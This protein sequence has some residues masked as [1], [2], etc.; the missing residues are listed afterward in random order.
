MGDLEFLFLLL[1]AAAALVR[2]ADVVRVPYPIVL[3]L[4]GLAAGYAPGSPELELEPEVVFL[5]FLPPL[6]YAAAW[7]ANPRELRAE[8][9]PVGLL[10][11]GLVVATIAAVAVVAHALVDGMSWG[12]AVVLG[13]V[14]APTDP[15]AA[16]ATFSRVGVPDRVR[17]L[18]EG[19]AMLNDAVPLVVFRVAIGVAAGESFLLGDAIGE[20]VLAAVGGIAVGLAVGWVSRRLVVRQDDEPLTILLTVLTAY[21]G[22]VVA[23]ELH[24]SGVLGAVVSGLYGG[25]HSHRTLDAGTR[26]SAVAFWQVLVF[27]LNALLFVLLGLQFPELVEDADLGELL[28][29]SL[30]IVL[31]LIAVR[32]LWLALP[33]PGLGDGVKERFLVGWSGMRGAISL[34]AALSVPAE[35]PERDEIILVTVL[36]IA[37]TLVGQ[38]LTLPAVIRGL[39]LPTVR[40]WS[41][42]EAIARLESS[43]AALDRLEE[44]EDEGADEEVLRRLVELYRARF[45]RCQVVLAGEGGSALEEETSPWRRASDVR[46]ELIEV[47]RRTLLELRDRGHLAPAVLRVI[48]RDLDLEEARLR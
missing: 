18:I 12:A 29:A 19:E 31:T 1:V 34:A 42:D 23:E 44:L 48:E 41:P 45:H 17:L 13:A 16:L 2:L 37:V 15:V 46:R 5:V 39:R 40:P 22:Y 8:F 26:L 3:V 21:A 27:V 43:Q 36:A 30:A 11:V 33:D 38:G 7:E 32:L 14:L 9:R 20:F 24:V 4:G 6:L 28:V 10:V 25:W 35:V 47:E